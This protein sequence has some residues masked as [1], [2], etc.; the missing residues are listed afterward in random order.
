MNK[1]YIKAQLNHVYWLTGSACSGKT[2]ISKLLEKRLGFKRIDDDVLKYRA[3]SNKFEY[4]ALQMPNPELNWEEWFNQS[5]EIMG[6]WMVDIAA[7]MIDFL[8]VDILLEGKSTPIVV[9]F[10]VEVQ[11]ITDYIPSE[12]ILG[13]FATDDMI[14]ASYLYRDDHKHILDRIMKSTLNPKSSASK[15]SKSVV[16]FSKQIHTS[17]Y[18]HQIKTLYRNQI[19]DVDSQLNQVCELLKIS[20][21]SFDSKDKEERKGS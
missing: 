18:E 4:P 5:P 10:A 7:E 16:W 2:T 21:D 11:R 13:M 17:C 14:E 15:M 6:Q 19:L 9:D 3:F 12:N 1:N 20:K 8:L